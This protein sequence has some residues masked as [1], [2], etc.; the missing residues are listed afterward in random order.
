MQTIAAERIEGQCRKLVP[1]TRMPDP[2]IASADDGA[3]DK[4][5]TDDLRKYPSALV[6]QNAIYP[7]RKSISNRRR[8]KSIPRLGGWPNPAQ[9]TAPPTRRRSTAVY[10]LSGLCA[11][12]PARVYSG[13]C[14]GTPPTESYP[15][16]KGARIELLNK[17]T[18]LL[19]QYEQELGQ[20]MQP[21]GKAAFP[22]KTGAMLCDTM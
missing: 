16:R 12:C 8:T 5:G 19:E 3:T 7:L 22:G 10:R 15:V 21:F 1:A 14:Y 11:L 6:H 18:C 17:G 9:N 13:G 2:V 4:K 20:G